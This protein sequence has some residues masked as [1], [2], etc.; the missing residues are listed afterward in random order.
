M[1]KKF[2]VFLSIGYDIHEIS[3]LP[4]GPYGCLFNVSTFI[5]KLTIVV[6]AFYVGLLLSTNRHCKE[7]GCMIFLEYFY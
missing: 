7:K 6:S 3:Q 5:V 2:A 1:V 4:F